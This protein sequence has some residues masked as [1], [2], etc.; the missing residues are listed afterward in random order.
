MAS[1]KADNRGI[2]PPH[3]KWIWVI[4][5]PAE[6][7]LNNNNTAY[8]FIQHWDLF[9]TRS[10]YIADAKRGKRG[11]A[12]CDWFWFYFSLD[13]EVTRVFFLSQWRSVKIQNQLLFGNRVKTALSQRFRKAS[14]P[15]R[16][17]GNEVRLGTVWLT[18][19]QFRPSLFCHATSGEGHSF[20]SIAWQ[21]AGKNWTRRTST[22]R[23]SLASQAMNTAI[24]CSFILSFPSRFCWSKNRDE[25]YYIKTSHIVKV[26]R[27]DIQ[28]H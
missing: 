5:Q 20:S 16:E 24:S 18:L 25:R 17:L 1:S 4:R 10:Y 2:I 7:Q 8:E 22:R 11:R 6:R 19:V 28:R 23:S 3:N 26:F 15:R 27:E 9:K 14:F 21:R 13:E 12:S